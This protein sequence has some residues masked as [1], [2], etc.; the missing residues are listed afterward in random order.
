MAEKDSARVQ[1]RSYQLGRVATLVATFCV[2][3]IVQAFAGV[4]AH[5]G[6]VYALLALELAM[7]F[8]YFGVERRELMDRRSLSMIGVLVDTLCM[9]AGVYLVGAEAE[10][11]GLIIFGFLVVMAATVHSSK[12]AIGIGAVSSGLYAALLLALHSGWITWRPEPIPYDIETRWPLMPAL[13]NGAGVMALALVAG[14]LSN[15]WRQAQAEADDLNRELEHRVE[16]RTRELTRRNVSLKRSEESIRLYARAVSHDIRSPVTAALEFARLIP[17]EAPEKRERY[18]EHVVSSLTDCESM[19]KGLVGVM[20]DGADIESQTPVSFADSLRE[21]IDTEFNGFDGIRVDGTFADVTVK[22][23]ALKHITRN[24]IGNAIVHNAGRSELEIVIGFDDS[25]DPPQFFVSDN[26]VGV[27]PRRIER[28]FRPFVQGPDPDP[29]G[30]GLGLYSVERMI[31]R[32]GGQVWAE[33]REGQGLTV[34]FTLP[35][36][37]DRQTDGG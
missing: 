8:L 35:T 7:T 26:G 5:I 9:V 3:L 19:L 16:Q 29:Q 12:A 33:S 25:T 23:E 18:L 28:I 37:A 17:D 1:F 4:N 6:Y 31:V 15:S 20:R 34:F 14:W 32:S 30:L 13:A 2:L 21:V 24:L 11:Y 36:A 10:R 27:E 22:P